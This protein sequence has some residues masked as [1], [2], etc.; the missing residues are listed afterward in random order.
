MHG[1]DPR[2]SLFRTLLSTVLIRTQNGCLAKDGRCIE[3]WNTMNVALIR[4]YLLHCFQP[5]KERALD[6]PFVNGKSCLFSRF[7]YRVNVG[8]TQEWL[9]VCVCT[10][11]GKWLQF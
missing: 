1:A 7:F 2:P 3:L 10:C 5:R 9:R 11:V 6:A 4:V 8:I